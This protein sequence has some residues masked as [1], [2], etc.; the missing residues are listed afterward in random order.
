MTI[1]G[2]H[3]EPAVHPTAVPYRS[4]GPP[5]TAPADR[6]APMFTQEQLDLINRCE[7]DYDLC[8]DSCAP[9]MDNYYAW[10]PCNADCLQSWVICMNP[11]SDPQG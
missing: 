8:E 4:P 2:F 1:P 10:Q 6:I 7:H 9:L 3:T 5:R 11:G